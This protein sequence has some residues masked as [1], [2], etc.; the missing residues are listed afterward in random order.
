MLLLHHIDAFNDA[1]KMKAITLRNVPP[2]IAEAIAARAREKGLS[3]NKTVV[4]ML[5]EFIGSRGKKKRHHD[6]DSFRGSWTAEEADEMDKAIAEQ[7]RP[8]PELWDVENSSG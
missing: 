6:L 8:D 4:G 3:I 2:A 1:K 7:R 5:E